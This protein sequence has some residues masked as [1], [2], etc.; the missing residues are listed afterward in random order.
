MPLLPTSMSKRIMRQI[1][2]LE[3]G[4]EKLSSLDLESP[5]SIDKILCT[6]QL[7]DAQVNGTLIISLANL[8]FLLYCCKVRHRLRTF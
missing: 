1:Q 2:V 8:E 4:V 5:Q 3:R 6:P 7:E